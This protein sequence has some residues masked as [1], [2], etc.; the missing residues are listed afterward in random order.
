[1]L[2]YQVTKE[3]PKDERYTLTSDMRRAANSVCH[4][5][6][7]GFGRF[8]SRDK[9]RFYKMSRGS[10][11][12]LISQTLVSLHLDYLTEEIAGTLMDGYKDVISEF[13]TLIKSIEL[14]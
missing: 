3:Y 11:Y 6:A 12:E 10:A 13:D 7:E 5:F 4:N 9:T 8:E 1:V 2:V 14:R